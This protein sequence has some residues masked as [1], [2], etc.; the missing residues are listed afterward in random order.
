MGPGVRL[1]L[2]LLALVM[3]AACGSADVRTVTVPADEPYRL[4]SGDQL[5]ITVFGQEEMTGEYLVDGSGYISM[6]LLA[7][8]EARGHTARDLEFLITEKLRSGK[9]LRN[10]SVNVQVLTYRP[11]FILGEVAQPG[12]FDYVPHMT[13]LTAVAMAGGFTYRA[14]TGAFTIVRKVG[15]KVTEMRAERMTV[16]RPG[17]TI[18]VHQ[19]IF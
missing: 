4:D 5:R 17:D 14:S 12:Q 10:P 18:Y 6:P 3:V 1:L 2:A 13:V 15:D 11:F 16:V 9:F 19:R 8:V 7:E